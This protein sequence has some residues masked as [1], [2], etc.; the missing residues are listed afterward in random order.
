MT[1]SRQDVADPRLVFEIRRQPHAPPIRQAVSGP[2]ITLGRDARC[3]ISFPDVPTVSGRHAEIEVRGAECTITDSRSQN[4]T[5]VNGVR[6]DGRR[7]LVAHDEIA[8]GMEGPR[9][10]L[11][12]IGVAGTPDAAA[13]G[14]PRVAAAV[15]APPPA[16]RPARELLVAR[17]AAAEWRPPAPVEPPAL[18]AAPV[19]P[20]A[21]APVAGGSTPGAT[22]LVR[23]LGAEVGRLRRRSWTV[24]IV[25]PLVLLAA[26]AAAWFGGLVPGAT[27]WRG[28]LAKAERSVVFIRCRDHGEF[29]PE[30]FLESTGS[31]F[32]VDGRGRVATNFHVIEGGDEVAVR[33]PGDDAWHRSSGFLVASREHDLAVIE[34][35]PGA[36]AGRPALRLEPRAPE[37]T[38]EVIAIGSPGGVEFLSSRGTVEKTTSLGSLAEQLGTSLDPDQVD[39]DDV[40]KARKILGAMRLEYD[41]LDAGGR[42]RFL[43]EVI[44]IDEIELTKRDLIRALEAELAEA[45][46]RSGLAHMNRDVEVLVHS[47]Q[48]AQ[49]NSGGPLLDTSGSVIGVNSA[50]LAR[51]GV[52]RDFRLA[53]AAK[54]LVERLP[55]ADATAKPFTDLPR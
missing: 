44:E 20:A 31:G 27:N 23:Q 1:Y 50:M 16:G 32:L 47:A 10:R 28:L 34:L 15:D 12:S 6:V 25:L 38:D 33:F 54:H 51:S 30:L 40:A 29:F 8:L 48:I 52:D 11:V 46:Q 3:T 13:G 4:H 49:G 19:V 35:A 24:A 22:T 45:R 5:Y 55:A 7:S 53:V 37:R 17:R 9:L 43:D 41:R 21:A 18:P 36:A 26:G 14:A 39:E 42:Q 2:T